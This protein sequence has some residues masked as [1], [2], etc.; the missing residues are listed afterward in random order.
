MRYTLAGVVWTPFLILGCNAGVSQNA[1]SRP[2]ISHASEMNTNSTSETS[3]S[4]SKEGTS[5]QK[6]VKT[7]EE[8]RKELS[9]EAYHILREG[10][11]ERAFSGEYYNNKKTGTYLCGAC[12]AALFKSEQKYD[13]GSG[14]PS[15]W[16]PVNPESVETLT[17]T[18]LGVART[19]IRCAR[20]G[21][22]LGHVF[23]DGP[24]P[25]GLRY[26]V[27]SASLDFKAAE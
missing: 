22:H 23:E 9:P 1:Q 24:K 10:G 3:M 26:C 15:Y 5:P 11:T 19:E 27:N 2:A 12:G 25:S 18:S 14:W 4:G 21:G 6:V 13:S 20:C 16:A 17:D 7:D 8:W